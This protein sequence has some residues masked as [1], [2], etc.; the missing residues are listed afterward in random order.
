MMISGNFPSVGTKWLNDAMRKHRALK[1]L[2]LLLCLWVGVYL[3]ASACEYSTSSNALLIHKTIVKV[4]GQCCA[5][6]AI[7]TKVGYWVNHICH[8]EAETPHSDVSACDVYPF[9]VFQ[10]NGDRLAKLIG[11]QWTCAATHVHD[12][13]LG[14]R[15]DEYQ[16]IKNSQ[17]RYIDTQLKTGVIDFPVCRHE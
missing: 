8:Y 14:D 17:G 6:F 16:L 3:Q 9:G 13:R 7:S 10:L 4:A 11:K 12:H 2:Q 5:V 1:K 15:F